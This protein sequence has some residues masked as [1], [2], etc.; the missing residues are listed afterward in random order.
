MKIDFRMYI[1]TWLAATLVHPY[2]HVNANKHDSD[3]P[4]AYDARILAFIEQTEH[5]IMQFGR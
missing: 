4:Y 1:R 3:M 2:V 5:L